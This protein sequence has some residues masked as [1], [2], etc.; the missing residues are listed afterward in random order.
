[1]KSKIE[2][3]ADAGKYPYVK[4]VLKLL[5]LKG[6]TGMLAKTIADILKVGSIEVKNSLAYLEQNGFVEGIEGAQGTKYFLAE[7][8]RNYCI[9]KGY[10][11]A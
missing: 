11:S 9:K 6:E 4:I 7:R 10:I 1:M 8:G 2:H 5:A 3:L